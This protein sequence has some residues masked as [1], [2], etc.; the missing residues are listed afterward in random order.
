MYWSED[1]ITWDTRCDVTDD[2]WTD[3]GKLEIEL[4]VEKNAIRASM[5]LHAM[6]MKAVETVVKDDKLLALF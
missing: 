3:T 6:M 5:E 2:Y 4:S 1:A